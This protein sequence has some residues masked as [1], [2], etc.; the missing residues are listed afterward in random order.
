MPCAC[1]PGLRTHLKVQVR[2]RLLRYDTPRT[3]GWPQLVDEG[4]IDFDAFC[5][6]RE[7]SPEAMAVAALCK[8]P[9]RLRQLLA[10]VDDQAVLARLALEGPSSRVRQSAAHGD[11]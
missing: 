8:D 6:G 1:L 3:N 2:T 10:R 4:A 5:S 9:D 7:H 11:P